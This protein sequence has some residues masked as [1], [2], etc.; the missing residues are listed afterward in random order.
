MNKRQWDRYLEEEYYEYLKEVI[1]DAYESESA[2]H[3][4]KNKDKREHQCITDLEDE[5][6]IT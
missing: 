6:Q 5:Y 2:E 3:F 1:N 4:Y